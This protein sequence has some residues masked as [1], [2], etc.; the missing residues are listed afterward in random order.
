MGELEYRK[1][2]VGRSEDVSELQ[3][4]LDAA[5]DYFRRI[6]GETACRKQAIRE[7]EIVPE[8]YPTEEK[9]LYLILEE[10]VPIGCLD[11][12][13][14][15]PETSV[16]YIGLLLIVESHRGCGLGRRAADFADKVG[17][18]WGCAVLRLGVLEHDQNAL[19]FWS[20][21]GFVERY[22][23]RSSQFTG[24]IVVMER[25]IRSSWGPPYKI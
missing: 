16:A 18:E 9:S 4:V 10:G 13:N 23:K 8:G 21:Q 1:L 25:A 19:Y 3:D 12:L 5:P 20:R 2:S 11:M 17:G 14:G 24:K 15:Y 22:I 6:Q 7:L